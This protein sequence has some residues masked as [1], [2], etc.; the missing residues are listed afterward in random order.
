MGWKQEQNNATGKS[1]KKTHDLNAWQSF[2]TKAQWSQSKPLT[3]VLCME[4]SHILSRKIGK[5]KH[6]K[7]PPPPPH[8]FNT[9]PFARPNPSRLTSG[10][11][12]TV[13]NPNFHFFPL[14]L[15][16]AESQIIPL[17]QILAQVPTRWAD[18]N[19][20]HL[21]LLRTESWI[22]LCGLLYRNLFLAS[23]TVKPFLY[24]PCA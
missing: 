15:Y 6:N 5:R 18:G 23:A 3:L 16:P 4:N 13:S 20:S 11:S 10:A 14:L 9:F 7:I 1:N 2:M 17:T 8:A 24:L 12:A 22:G 19:F 21:L